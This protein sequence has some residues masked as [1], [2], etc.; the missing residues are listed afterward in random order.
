[1]AVKLTIHPPRQNSPQVVEFN[2]D[3]VTIGRSS[4]CD[5]RL[6]FRVVSGH[7]LTVHNDGL[8]GFQVR[9][10]AS[11]NGTSLDGEPLP[12][13]EDRRLSSGAELEIVDLRITVELVP[14]LGHGFSLEK[15][16]TMVRQMVGEALLAGTD[17]QDDERAYFEVLRGVNRGRRKELP[18]DLDRGLIADQLDA[19]VYVEGLETSV[20][21]YRDGDGFAV[22]PADDTPPGRPVTLGDQPLT[23]GRRL[24]SGDV[25]RVGSIEL[26]FVDPLESYLA[27]LEG[28]VPNG[29]STDHAGAPAGSGADALEADASGVVVPAADPDVAETLTDR[30]RTDSAEGPSSGSAWG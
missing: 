14:T 26:E 27:E 20:E 16:G 9:D 23:Q 7:H 18:D 24:T 29:S 21:I 15:T 2:E 28:L 17:D 19:D 4:K 13:G 5:I 6:P 11:T 8:S 10:E 22:G 1:M 30:K 12:A 25:L 3:H